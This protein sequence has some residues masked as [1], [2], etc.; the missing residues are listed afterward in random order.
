M[1]R[2]PPTFEELRGLVGHELGVSEWTMVDQARIDQFAACTGDRNWIH[3]DPEMAR[4]RSP[5][6]RTIAHGYLTLSLIASLSQE[7]GILPENTQGLFNHALEGVRFLA[8][9][10]SGTR[11]RLRVTLLAME[12]RGPGQYLLKAENRIEIE[13][14]E[15]PALVAETHVIL[16]E[17]RQKR[18][19]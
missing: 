11:V 10:V 16:Y 1:P 19:G 15:S 12:D 4:R 9:V 8:P 13:G 6:R 2:T 17:R 5:L 3:I 14:S 7:M 18:S